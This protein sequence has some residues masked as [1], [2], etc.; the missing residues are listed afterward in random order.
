MRHA[1]AAAIYL[2]WFGSVSV[3]EPHVYALKPWAH[4]A[5]SIEGQSLMGRGSLIDVRFGRRSKA[6]KRDPFGHWLRQKWGFVMWGL[7]ESKCGLNVSVLWFSGYCAHTN[8]EFILN[9]FRSHTFFFHLFSPDS[10]DFSTQ[11]SLVFMTLF[12]LSFPLLCLALSSLG[13]AS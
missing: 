5:R 3:S 8:V 1:N 9:P 4:N 7:R 10:L 13:A 11:E 2:C 12:L 6:F